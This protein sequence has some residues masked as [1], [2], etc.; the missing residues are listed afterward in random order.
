ML[1]EFYTLSDTRYTFCLCSGCRLSCTA[2][3]RKYCVPPMSVSFCLGFGGAFLALRP[4]GEKAS[5]PTWYYKPLMDCRLKRFQP[6]FSERRCCATRARSGLCFFSR[7]A[8][9][10]FNTECPAAVWS[11]LALKCCLLPLN[12]RHCF[13]QTRLRFA[14]VTSHGVGLSTDHML[15]GGVYHLNNECWELQ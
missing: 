5:C 4:T 11:I 9:L 6:H 14:V 7:N 8:Y 10:N 3:G 13:L 15:K 2:N 1:L 12:R